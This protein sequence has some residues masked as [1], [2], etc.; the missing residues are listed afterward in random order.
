MYSILATKKLLQRV[1]SEIAPAVADPTTV[2][3]NWYVTALFWKPQVALLVNEGT[4]LPVM[5]PLAPAAS[6][7]DR[8]PTVLAETFRAHGVPRDFIDAEVEHMA[9]GSYAKTA[10]RRMLGIM[11]SFVHMAT[12]DRS[13][14]GPTELLQISVWLSGVPIGPTPMRFPRA[15]LHGAVG[16]WLAGNE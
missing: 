13:F 2:L 4:L 1:N 9:D 15:E 7:L 6:L 3:G 11:N 10:S 5:M 16:V 12:V 14:S 8:F